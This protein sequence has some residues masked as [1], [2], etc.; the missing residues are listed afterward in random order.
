[1]F[2]FIFAL[3][4]GLACPSHTNTNNGNTNGINP[5]YST[6]DTGGET[7]QNPPKKG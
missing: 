2:S 6:F 3:L 4:M 1:M 7:G 5:P